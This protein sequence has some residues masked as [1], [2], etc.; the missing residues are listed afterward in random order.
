MDRQHRRDL[1]RDKFVDEVGSLT[2]RARENQRL[3][4]AITA[5]VVILAVIGYG[6]YFY[7]SN[8][9]QKAQSALGAAIEA[10]DSPLIQ[11]GT[12]NPNA[13]FSSEKE[14]TDRSEAMFRDVQKTYS[15][16]KAADV[17]NIFLARIAA[18]RNDTTTARKL[19]TDFISDHPKHLLVGAA[20]YSL[21]QIDRKST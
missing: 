3:L 8:R 12:P 14:R 6:V 11:P 15:G 17:A 5:A 20:R 2:T 19:L 16:T 13:K 1:K 7:G 21:Y 4:V 18:S 10:I 9:E